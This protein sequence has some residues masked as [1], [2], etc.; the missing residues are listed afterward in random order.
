MVSFRDLLTMFRSNKNADL[1]L[2][3][4]SLIVFW[5]RIVSAWRLNPKSPNLKRK[6]TNSSNDCKIPPISRSK[7]TKIWKVP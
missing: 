5:R 1:M 3:T 7:P 6:S 4:D 2:V